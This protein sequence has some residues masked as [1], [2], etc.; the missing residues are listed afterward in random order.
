M[1]IVYLS[2]LSEESFKI[3]AYETSAITFMDTASLKDTYR[4]HEMIYID[5]F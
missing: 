2:Y 3:N 1:I 4:L 5:I